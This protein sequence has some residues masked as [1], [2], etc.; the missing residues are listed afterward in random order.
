MRETAQEIVDTKY[1]LIG[2]GQARLQ[3]E[4]GES[5]STENTSENDK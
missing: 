5:K 2:K 1:L 4:A 3:T